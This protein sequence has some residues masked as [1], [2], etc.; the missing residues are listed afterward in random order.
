MC[1]VESLGL[2]RVGDVRR[3]RRARSASQRANSGPDCNVE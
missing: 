2:H 1:A 3:H